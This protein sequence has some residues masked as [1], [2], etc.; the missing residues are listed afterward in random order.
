[1]VNLTKLKQ[2]LISAY[3]KGKIAYNK[4][5]ELQQKL[6][7]VNTGRKLTKQ[8]IREITNPSEN[9]ELRDLLEF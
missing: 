9:K 8:E 4:Y 3:K 1:M 6:A 5:I 7:K 2:N